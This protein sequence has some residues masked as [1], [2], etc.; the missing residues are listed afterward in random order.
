MHEDFLVSSSLFYACT[1]VYMCTLEKY[2]FIHMDIH[3]L[4]YVCMYVYMNIFGPTSIHIHVI[5]GI[6]L[7]IHMLF[8]PSLE[9]ISRDLTSSLV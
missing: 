7:L 4:K 5:M 8:I 3:F 1:C 6:C 2:T 9:A